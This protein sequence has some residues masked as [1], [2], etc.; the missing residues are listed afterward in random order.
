MQKKFSA[1]TGKVLKLM[2]NSLYTNPS[3]FLRELISN[4]SDAC[5]KVRY[6][7]LNDHKLLD[8]PLQITIRIDKEQ[9]SL[10]IEDNGIGMD[11]KD[12]DE[13]LG[14]IASSGTQRF[15]EALEEKEK[16]ASQLIGQFGVGFYSAFMVTNKIFVYSTKLGTS[17]TYLWESEGLDNYTI[18]KS[19]E[20]L[21]RGTRVCLKMKS[22]TDEYLDKHK[23]KHIVSTYSDH[24]DFP[25]YLIDEDEKSEH[26]NSG[27]A[28]W[29]RQPSQVKKE[30]HKEFYRYLTHMPDEPWMVL[31]NKIEGKV[32]YTSLLYIPT[33]KPHDLFNPERQTRVRLYVKRIFI[34]DDD[35]ALIP[36]NLRFL[37]GIID[38]EDLPLNISRETLQKNT[39]VEQIRKSLVKKV[40][41]ALKKKVEKEPAEYEKFWHNFGEVLKEG[42]C[43]PVPEEGELLTEIC[44]FFTSKSEDK[45]VGLDEYIANMQEG[46]NIIYY[47]TGENLETMRNH[48]QLEGF[49]KR[50]IEVVLLKDPVDD[51]WLTAKQNYKNKP[52][53]YIASAN[54]NFDE[55]DEKS[56]KK[57]DK[58]K[59][60]EETQE[61][62]DALK[63][64]IKSILGGLIKEVQVSTKLAKSPSCLSISE[65]GM[66]LRMEKMLIEQRQLQKRFPKILEINLEHPILRFLISYVSKKDEKNTEKAEKFVKVIFAEASIMS[67][68]HLENPHII[69]SILD[70]L[71]IQ[72]IS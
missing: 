53:E 40:Y 10:I 20:S 16:N 23:I 34:A 4:A 49:K 52:L 1:E 56:K 54:I 59:K 28:I 63:D 67:G 15:L 31:H 42:L 25:I 65:G 68:E 13:N 2:I 48:P 64:Y 17:K 12:L 61:E 29:T 72:N 41:L 39:K 47:L 38:S 62:I 55:E 50:N 18:S 66:N 35:L 37:R 58:E 57:E 8:E 24:I 21:P 51:F 36:R 11:Q 26:L 27:Q 6:K 5:D 33:N 9:N 43:E 19:N 22:G 60:F 70:D 7:A 32:S 3:I 45:L 71:A 44:R 30:E 14:T 46:Q 69:S